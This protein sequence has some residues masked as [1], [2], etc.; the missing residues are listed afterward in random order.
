M[1]IQSACQMI[2][3]DTEWKLRSV[4]RYYIF[5][6][7][8]HVVTDPLASKCNDRSLSN[9]VCQPCVHD[10]N[11]KYTTNHASANGHCT[12]SQDSDMRGN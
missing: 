10:V 2:E 3:R 1:R 5:F 6:E 4:D 9:L 8:C 11:C 12:A 7:N